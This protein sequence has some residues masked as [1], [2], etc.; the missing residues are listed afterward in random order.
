MRAP[1]RRAH[2]AH[3]LRRG[4]GRK[5]DRRDE[6]ERPARRNAAGR[7]AA[8]P[9][10]RR[11]AGRPRRRRLPERR[12][13]PRPARRGTRGRPDLG[14]VRRRPRH[15]QLRR[16]RSTSSTPTSLDVVAP[17]C[18]LV[19]RRLSRD[20]YTTTTGQHE[21]EVEPDSLTV[22]RTTVVTYQVGR[23]V[24]GG[25]DNI[26]FAVSSDDGRTWR[27]GLLPGLTQESVPRGPAR[28]RERSG[29]RVR[30]RDAHVAHLDARDP[31]PDHAPHRQ[32]LE[33][34]LHVEQPGDRDRGRP[35][36]RHHLRQE[37]DHLRQRR[38]EPEARPV[39]P[40][41]HGHGPE[42]EH[43]RSRPRPTAA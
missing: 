19:G 41:V 40:R 42:R 9:R 37:L 10:R 33:R 31:K 23:R 43:R 15:R 34:R 30:R 2:A 14:G 28:A 39:L 13:R 27:S 6:P 25:A 12:A 8:R 5:D 22:G 3:A 29:R 7:C 1:G 18:E 32:P 16:R 11:P 35:P 38:R 4:G 36:E 26:G 17:D 24:D 20:P 21:T